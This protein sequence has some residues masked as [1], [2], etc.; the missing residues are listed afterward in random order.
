ME[1][2]CLIRI[3]GFVSLTSGTIY[4]TIGLQIRKPIFKEVSELSKIEKLFEKILRSPKEVRYDELVR[5]L[6]GLGYVQRP[7]KGSHTVFCHEELPAMTVP[8]H[9][10]VKQAYIL[11]VKEILKTYRN[12]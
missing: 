6:I 1:H 9:T 12:K 8:H 10:P 4:G 5:V 3:A 7:G 11:Q 2:R